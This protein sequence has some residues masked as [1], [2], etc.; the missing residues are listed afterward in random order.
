MST[1]GR[2][3]NSSSSSFSSL[4]TRECRNPTFTVP[5]LPLPRGP[6]QRLLGP[7]R[8]PPARNRSPHTRVSSPLTTSSVS[9]ISAPHTGHSIIIHFLIWLFVRVASSGRGILRSTNLPPQ[10]H[11][12]YPESIQLGNICSRASYHR[13]DDIIVWRW[14]IQIVCQALALIPL[15][16]S[17]SD[18]RST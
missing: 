5:N 7:I 15:I 9:E 10:Q 3:P 1:F 13:R 17:I 2:L 12:L 18:L 4:R 6:V 8:L 16:A 14:N 11:L